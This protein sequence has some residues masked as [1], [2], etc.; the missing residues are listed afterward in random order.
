[1]TSQPKIADTNVMLVA[2]TLAT[3]AHNTT[4]I[5]A[6]STAMIGATKGAMKASK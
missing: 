1:M 2:V 3:K 6:E 4:I 5:F